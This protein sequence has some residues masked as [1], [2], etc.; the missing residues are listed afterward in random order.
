MMRLGIRRTDRQPTETRAD[1]PTCP[2]ATS[3]KIGSGWLETY[4]RELEE[5]SEA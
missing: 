4:F 1:T 2:P 5:G 3:S